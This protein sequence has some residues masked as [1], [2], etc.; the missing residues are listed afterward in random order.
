MERHGTALTLDRV[1]APDPARFRGP[2][3]VEGLAETVRAVVGWVG[4]RL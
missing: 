3:A 4:E 2:E 1:G